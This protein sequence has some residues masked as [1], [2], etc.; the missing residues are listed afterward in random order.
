[1]ILAASSD[2]RK[3]KPY[4]VLKG[5]GQARD[6]KALKERKDIDIGLSPTGWTNDDVIEDWLNCNFG[7]TSFHKRLLI[8]D[9]FRAHLS[10]ATKKI[11]KRKRM[12]QAII[13][14]GCTSILQAPDVVWNKP[15]KVST[16]SR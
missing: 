5:K 10:D 4:I 8:W 3:K 16:N 11:L 2:G 12:D 14:G 13:P 7:D 15:F 9:S 1:M 6:V